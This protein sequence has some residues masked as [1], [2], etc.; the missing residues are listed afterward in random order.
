MNRKKIFMIVAAVLLFAAVCVAPFVV[1]KYILRMVIMLLITAILGQSW[2]LMSGYAGQ[3]SFGHAVFF[4]I[5]AYT[6]AILSVKFGLS[7]LFGMLLGMVIGAAVGMFIGYLSFRYRLK[8]DYFALATLAF[9]EIFRVLFNN[10]KAFG[11]AQGIILPLPSKNDFLRFEFLDDEIYYFILVIMVVAVSL[12]IYYISRCRFGLNLV[13]IRTNRGAA[14]ALGVNV[15]SHQLIAIGISGAVA[16]AAGAVYAQVYGYI[17]PTVVFAATISVRAIVPCI[18]GGSGTV[19]GPIL[20][21]LIIVPLQEVCNAAFT[22]VKGLN[23][24]LYGG[25]IVIFVLFCPNGVLGLVNSIKIKHSKK[26]R[27]ETV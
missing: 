25:L 26:K 22:E 9:A 1:N 23:M 11:G 12:G 5:G 8:G 2:N 19:M 16:A 10:T 27:G 3:F 24:I 20:G 21:A 13:A 7:S 15:L 17:D 14:A 18:I 4:G 6:S